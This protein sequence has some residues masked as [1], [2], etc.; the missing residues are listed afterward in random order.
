MTHNENDFQKRLQFAEIDK[1]TITTLRNLW[2]VI[3]PNL[4][5]VLSAFYSHIKRYP[6]LSEMIGE[7]QP[8]L[9]S[10]QES[11][12]EKLFN[13]G[14]DQEYQDSINRVGHVH[15][16]IGLEP[17]WYIG[18]Y[19][20]VLSRLHSTI[21]RKYKRTLKDRTKYL[22]A[23]TAAVFLDMDLAISTYEEKLLQERAEQNERQNT[24]IESFQRKV[25][26]PL[27]MVDQGARL[28]S[29]G[30]GTLTTVSKSAQE[31]VKHATSVSMDTKVSVQTVASATEE[32]SSSIQEISKQITGASTIASQAAAGTE[33][34]SQQ[35]AGLSGAA[36]KIGDVVGLI[37]AIAE[38]T[39]LLALNATIEAAR[40]GDAGKGFAVVASEVKV[41]AEQTAK[42][43]EEIDQQVGEI[44]QSTGAAVASIN[45]ISEV[46]K[47]LNE[48]T[49]SAAAAVEEQGA[50]T[51][52]ISQSIQTLAT[53][54]ESLDQNISGVGEAIETT[55]KAASDFL[56]AADSM[57]LSTNQI[58]QE[59]RDF[60]EVLQTGT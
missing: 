29:D 48:M 58:S 42:A 53:G 11:H 30:A 8:Q 43:T 47:E 14:F 27:E 51:Q 15:C 54:A 60:F 5:E 28:I 25:E 6:H 22:T 19:N 35:V 40:A 59:I 2:P 18:G 37:H 46:V 32:L 13:N 39:N 4:G 31:Q 56:E 52:E 49:A 16:R 9:M 21:M 44:Q 12:W 36:Q 23:I 26:Q 41:L 20:F 3:Q 55:D 34:S 1:E 57:N 17:R 45:S 24:A 10:A 33:E 7:L 50:A 38:Q